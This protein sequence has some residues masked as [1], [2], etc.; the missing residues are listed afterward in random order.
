MRFINIVDSASTFNF[1]VWNAAVINAGLLKD[2]GIK[3]ELWYMGVDKVAL[4]DVDAI[5][6]TDPGYKALEILISTRQLHADQDIIITSG[7]WR[8]PT[9]WGAFLKAKGFQWIFVPQGM[10]EP[11]PLKQ[12]WLQKKIYFNILEKHLARKATLI[13]AV[14]KPE[15]KNLKRFFPRNRIE[16]IPNGVQ[17]ANKN[18]KGTDILPKVTGYLFLSRLHH[19]KNVVAL[20][21][22]WVSSK[23]NNDPLFQLTIAGPDQGELAKLQPIISSS[24][25]LRY[26]GVVK[27]AAKDSL[28]NESTFYILP[29]FSEGLPSALLEAMARGIIPI[30][31]EGCNFPDVFEHDLGIRITTEKLS[32]QLGLEDS[33]A[34]DYGTIAEKSRQC[35]NLIQ[36]QYSLE[37]VT[38]RQL[39]AYIGY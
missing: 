7:V 31:T 18:I 23:L 37:A 28:F 35:R 30:I 5:N 34:W 26:V 39:Q 16:F 2:A 15:V 11:W 20:A 13:R 25:N 22:A 32:I 24:G 27:G 33:S 36:S 8:Y 10:L 12:K 19:K 14:S 21:K 38:R 6:I 1:G 4:P 3:T 9:R 17:A 29:S